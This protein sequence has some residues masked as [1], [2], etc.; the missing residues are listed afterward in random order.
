M[1]ETPRFHEKAQE[2]KVM[3]S[4]QSF[5]R[6][7]VFFFDFFC[8]AFLVT[9]R[10]H[11]VTCFEILRHQH[12]VRVIFKRANKI[13]KG[14][15][16]SPDFQDFAKLVIKAFYR[17]IQK[18]TRNKSLLQPSSAFRFYAHPVQQRADR[19][20]HRLSRNGWPGMKPRN[21]KQTS[22]R[23]ASQSGCS[24]ERIMASRFGTWN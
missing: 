7:S 2:T 3:K 13:A 12:I 8:F 17:H 18:I 9:T 20:R 1:V 21:S 11:F 15:Q 24:Q 23:E 10:P 14:S 4:F 16:K 22:E 6:T 5:R 19:Q